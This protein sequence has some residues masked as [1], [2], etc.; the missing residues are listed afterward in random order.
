MADLQETKMEYQPS[1]TGDTHSPPAKS[2]M[3]WRNDRPLDNKPRRH[4]APRHYA[5]RPYAP[6]TICPG[7]HYAPGDNMPH[8]QYAPA[9]NMPWVTVCPETIC[10]ETL[11]PGDN[12]PRWTLCPR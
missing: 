7:G 5:L 3:G 2:K 8:G 6:V 12:M 10:P 4:Y 11:C 1:S 9:D